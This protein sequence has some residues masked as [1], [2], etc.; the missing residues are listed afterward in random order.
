MLEARQVSVSYGAMKVL[1]AVDCRVAGGEIVSLLGP[2]GA[3]KSSLVNAIAGLVSL[4][5]GH[6]MFDGKDISMAPP[7]SRVRAGVSLVM[8]RH[9]LFP[10]MTVR[11]NLIVGGYGGGGDV[12][13]YE[14]ALEL[15]PV[16]RS[17]LD[18]RAGNLSGGQQ[19]MVAL[20]RGLMATPR[21]LMID[22]PYLGLA[23]SVISTINAFMEQL[24]SRGVGLLF[25]EQAVNAALDISDRVYFLK[26]GEVAFSG[27]PADARRESI[28]E[29]V[30][31]GGRKEVLSATAP[32][33]PSKKSRSTEP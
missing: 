16:L 14:E 2:N 29:E 5:S 24:R 3:G 8:E 23:P 21:I 6:I 11:E 22:E 28:V 17:H 15:F 10:F 25:I 12:T 31:F 19:Q 9:R 27:T 26:S 13:P 4:S 20:A 1:H 30:Y 32:A 18:E 7:H 33:V